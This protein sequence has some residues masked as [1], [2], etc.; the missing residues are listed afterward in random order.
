MYDIEGMN[1]QQLREA[2]KYSLELHVRDKELSRKLLT[3]ATSSHQAHIDLIL[4]TAGILAPVNV[5]CSTAIFTARL[6]E[7]YSSQLKRTTSKGK[8]WIMEGPKQCK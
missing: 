1:E 5:A 7:C 3:L 8:S 2:L 6:R 4:N